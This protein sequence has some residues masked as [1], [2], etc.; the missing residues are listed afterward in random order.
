[1]N[2]SKGEREAMKAAFV[3]RFKVERGLVDNP[4]IQD[5]INNSATAIVEYD[6]YLKG[7]KRNGRDKRMEMVDVYDGIISELVSY[8]RH[9]FPSKKSL[10]KWELIF[11]VHN[12][13]MDVKPTIEQARLETVFG[14]S[15]GS[16][17]VPHE[18]EVGQDIPDTSS[19][20]AKVA[21]PVVAPQIDDTPSE[22]VVH[23][24]A[25]K[26]PIV[27]E[28]VTEPSDN[29]E[30]VSEAQVAD[31]VSLPPSGNVQAKGDAPL[32]NKSDNM[33]EKTMNNVQELLAAAAGSAPANVG[34]EQ[35]APA[36]NTQ[37]VK[38]DV[39][40][41]QLAVSQIMSAEAEE[42]QQWT[43]SNVVT[44]IISTQKP[45]A[46]RRTADEGT[47]GTETDP[48]KQASAINDKLTG[49]IAAVSGKKG[50][51]VEQFE[52]LAQTERYANVVPGVTKVNDVEVSNLDKAAAI[53]A[54][55]K[56]VKQNPA[57]PVAAFIP[58]KL[59][60][61][62]KGYAVAGNKMSNDE[63]MLLLSDKSNGAIYAQG[64]VNADGVEVEGATSFKLMTAKKAEKAQ[65]GAIRTQT[66]ER[67]VPVIRI[68]NKNNFIG[69]GKNVI[70]L[71][72]NEDAEAIGSAAFRAAINVNGVLVSAGVTVYALDDEG[73]TQVISHNDKT[74]EDRYKTKQASV[75][76]SVPVRKVL[77]EFAP[78]FKGDDDTIVAAGRW[79]VNMGAS[80]AATADFCNI[81]EFSNTP[82]YDVFTQAFAGNLALSGK[83]K[84]SESM[85][86]LRAAANQAAADAAA[87]AEGALS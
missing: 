70:Y 43:K 29:H 31:D 59:S 72:P 11:D 37:A 39:K 49:F 7:E 68:K 18:E 82:I 60:Y 85:K 53:Y 41:A 80:K 66:V 8:L 51:T 83:M 62:V 48:T 78:E 9:L 76:V 26:E 69:D 55:L 67:R 21:E 86:K 27:P 1:M 10:T 20:D 47:V 38:A 13:I 40:A 74:G 61:P 30:E 17:V 77:R 33:E 19:E 3:N 63:F 4:Q 75:S 73:K 6:G 54:L 64:G 65:A 36:S 5:W 57:A 58:T 56:S 45:A 81:K 79:G 32:F 87:D 24:S 22:E 46:M 14:A 44:A 42:R 34:E 50:I 35:K 23:I 84:E 2:Y 12:E 28:E 15:D 16:D 25:E 52:A 71:F